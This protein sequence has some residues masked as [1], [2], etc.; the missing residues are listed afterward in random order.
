MRVTRSARLEHFNFFC[1]QLTKVLVR[2]HHIDIKA[3]C[4]CLLSKGANDVICFIA[5]KPQCRNLDGLQKLVDVWDCDLNTL[6]CGIPVGFVVGIAFR[7]ARR[8]SNVKYHSDVGRLLLI[9][10]IKQGKHEAVDSRGVQPLTGDSWVADE[11]KMCPE[12]QGKGIK[13]KEFGC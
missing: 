1:H 12:N 9:Q 7:A 13:E 3:L 11:G 8:S 2:C 10:H 4:F 6:R 5:L